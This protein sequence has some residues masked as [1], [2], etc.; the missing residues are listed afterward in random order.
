MSVIT[1]Q[2]GEPSSFACFSTQLGLL[3]ERAA[4]QAAGERVDIRE[5]LQFL[6]LR[7]DLLA[8]GLELRERALELAFLRSSSV[9]SVNETRHPRTAPRPSVIGLA[10]SFALRGPSSACG[11]SSMSPV[12]VVPSRIATAHG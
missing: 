12:T 8:R 6:V 3:E 4:V 1:Q 11:I 9:T 10:A 5:A 2:T 7:L